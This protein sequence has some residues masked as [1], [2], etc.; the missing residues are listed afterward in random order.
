MA[1]GDVLGGLF[2]RSPIAPIQHHMSV[3]EESVQLLCQL[4]QACVDGDPPRVSAIYT[5]LDE[6]TSQANAL[7]RQIRQQMPRGLFLAMSRP[8]L[9]LLLEMQE[10]LSDTAQE[11]ARPLSLRE[12]SIPASLHKSLSRLSTLIAACSSQCLTAIRELDE[13]VAE[14]FGTH[15]R[16]RIE[17]ML[18][19][20]DKQLLRYG[21]QYERMFADLVRSEQSL[22]NLDA[23]F[24]Y[25]M[26]D[27]LNRLAATCGELG[28]QLRLIMAK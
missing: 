2:G 7:R 26:T 17:K 11:I 10:R 25:R 24:F 28:E 22:D 9:L 6:N 18:N 23:F 13:L 15:E 4:I 8:D 3:A 14:G 16:R 27:G 20:L 1:I 12:M 19:S 21:A 5:Q